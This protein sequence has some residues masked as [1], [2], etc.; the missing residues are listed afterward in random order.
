M[1]VQAL[2]DYADTYL[3]EQ[4]KYEAW[5]DKPVPYLIAVDETGTFLNCVPNH[6]AAVRGKK[7]VSVPALLEVPRSPVPRN[8]G[9]YPL[10]GADD[11]KYVLGAGP[12]TPKGQEVNN[13]ERHEAFVSLIRKAA[14]DTND[15]G[16]NAAAAFYSRPD[17]VEAARKALVDIKPGSILALALMNEALVKRTAIKTYWSQ[18]YATASSGR[19]AKG[20][21][22]ECLISAKI[23]PIAPTHEK[24]KGLASLGG[25]AAG[26]S[27]MSFDKDA[28]CSY[29]W[30]QNAN[31]PVAPDR[32]MAYVL[33]LNDLLRRDGKHRRDI[34][35]VGF[36]FWT[37][38]RTE[39]DAMSMVDQPEPEQI[40]RLLN[41]NP[42]ANPDPN[43]FYM[44]GVAANG[45][46][47]LI[48][49]WI[50][51]TL[52]T[53]KNNLKEWFEG[54]RVTDVFTGMLS[55][56]PKLWQLLYALEREGNPPAD[57]VVALIRRAIEGPR[58]PL[59]YRILAAALARLRVA[60]ANRLDPARIG[61]IRLCLNDQIRLRDIEGGFMTEGLD[62]GQKHPAY[63]C[64]RL[65]AV[66]ESLQYA[67]NK[68]LN[69]T[70]A[71]RY[72]TLASTFPQQAFPKIVDL[73]NVH[74]RKLRRDNPGAR[75][76][77]SSEID[78]LHV[79][80]EQASDFKYPAALD[81]DGQ[82]RFALGY[83][84]QRAHQIAQAKA[85][86]RAK[87][88]SNSQGEQE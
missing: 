10:L 27:L 82:G 56:P 36:V 18:L 79:E 84:H 22:A 58:Q 69:Q 13:Q 16:L 11:I 85:A 44:A 67:T 71:D 33:A 19:V 76:R 47:M 5:E 86:T 70:V 21:D 35:G 50:S 53:V 30:E 54:L 1:F 88:E 57:R 39:F 9:L 17:Q 62:I 28:F 6:V 4:L 73:G 42:L 80:I 23:G 65:M 26:V 41:L 78:Q 81:L 38:E 14:S 24:I 12:W 55:E 51:E 63:L 64:G 87:E 77:L 49:C 32:A 72:Y 66:Y 68:D 20:G 15:T 31:S 83:H 60:S 8:A 7:T 3:S 59:G 48:R 37:R 40:R 34:A 75:Y 74:L 43:R 46:R 2:A 29:G 25:Q 45:G 52:T 61:L